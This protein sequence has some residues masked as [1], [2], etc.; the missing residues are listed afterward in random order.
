[1]KLRALF[2]AFALP[3]LIA[4]LASADQASIPAASELRAA[5]FSDPASADCPD[6]EVAWLE[7]ISPS[8]A[9]TPCGPCSDSLCQGK[10]FGQYCDFQGGQAYYCRFA[11]VVCHPRD[12]Q[13]WHGPLP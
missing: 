12:C 2:L 1:M 9:G 6:P 8:P 3:L 5:I 10:Q 7:G 4:P 11:Y 13:C